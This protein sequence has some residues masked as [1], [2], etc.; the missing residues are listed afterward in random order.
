ARP[1]ASPRATR[2]RGRRDLPAAVLRRSQARRST[3]AS[4]S[5]ARRA[6]R[7]SRRAPPERRSHSCRSERSLRF[8]P[9]PG[10]FFQGTAEWGAGRR[11]L[12][13][14][15]AARALGRRGGLALRGAQLAPRV[16]QLA[17]ELADLVGRV[18]GLR[19]APFG[20]APARLGFLGATRALGLL[21]G[22]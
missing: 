20:I 8:V 11:R 13:I 9:W 16:R 22:A 2:G 10:P 5:A 18:C 7:S 17:L 6:S 14:G 12:R 21:P 19:G 4:R 15:G 3:R 1:V